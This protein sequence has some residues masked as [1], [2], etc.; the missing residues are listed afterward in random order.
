MTGRVKRSDNESLGVV[1]G[2]YMCVCVAEVRSCPSVQCLPPDEGARQPRP[3][4]LGGEEALRA[5]REGWSLTPAP[6][7]PQKSEGVYTVSEP[8]LPPTAPVQDVSR[9]QWMLSD[10]WKVQGLWG[11][12]ARVAPIPDPLPPLLLQG[13]STRTQETYETLKHEKPPQ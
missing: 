4:A 1:S 8:A 7:P 11:G 5:L 3:A 13:L 6:L 9:E 10:L 12:R 2:V